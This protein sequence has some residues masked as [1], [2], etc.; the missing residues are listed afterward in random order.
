MS[1]VFRPLKVRH[2]IVL[3]DFLDR[4]ENRYPEHHRWMPAMLS[5]VKSAVWPPDRIIRQGPWL[6]WEA[7]CN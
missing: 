3:N 1:V 4:L 2:L 6:K 7:I 5:P